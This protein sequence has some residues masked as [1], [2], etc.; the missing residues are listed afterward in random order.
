MSQETN[1][2]E[3]VA[4]VAG[5]EITQEEFNFFL[6]AVPREQQ[7]YLANPQFRQQCLDQFI[8]LRLY[9]KLGEE[10]K[11]EET[12]EFQ[13]MIANAKRDILAQ[14]A[15][16]ETLKAASVSE[17]EAAAYYE[18]NKEQ[19]KK[20][21]TVR[22]KHILTETEKNAQRFLLRSRKMRNHSRTLRKNFPLAHPVL[23]AEILAHLEE[24]RW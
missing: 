5:E 15:M 7:A 19:Y 16:R 24:D 10:L 14:I 22:A 18:E 17:E 3:V 23:R 8:A 11:L 9:A 6:Q 12:E 20:G 4:V 2:K 21:E 13:T 1:K